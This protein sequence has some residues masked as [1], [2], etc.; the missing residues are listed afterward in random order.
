M[1]TVAAP[2]PGREGHRPEVDQGG[3][4]VRL[5]QVREAPQENDQLEGARGS[6]DILHNMQAG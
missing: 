2:L 1:R 5:P 3:G 4:R 6:A